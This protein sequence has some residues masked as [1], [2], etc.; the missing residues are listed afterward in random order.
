MKEIIIQKI[1]EH[2]LKAGY[3]AYCCADHGGHMKK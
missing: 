2:K 1:I 3:Q